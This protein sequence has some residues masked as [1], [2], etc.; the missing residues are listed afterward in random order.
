MLLLIKLILA[1]LLGDFV[2]QSSRWV[3]QKELKRHLAWQLYAHSLLHG[4]LVLLL[5]ADITYWVH[6]L[7]ITVSHLII[8]LLKIRIQNYH[9][10]RLWFVLD[11]MLHLLVILAVW[12]ASESPQ[13]DFQ[14][15]SSPAFFTI[16]TAVVFLTIPSSVI[17]K[18]FISQWTPDLLPH[19]ETTASLQD[20]G[21]FIGMLE[22]LFVFGFILS[23]N[24]EAIGFLLAAKSVFRFGDLRESKDRKLTE[25]VLI[26]T[27]LS[28]GLAIVAGVVT[29]HVAKDAIGKLD[30]LKVGLA[31]PGVE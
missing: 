29:L 16:L 28:F 4:F 27:L 22:R 25:Y 11:Q 23:N 19:G 7:I 1:H 17:I 18:T 26:G 5:M 6:A 15:L 20:A 10:R 2:F 30:L 12:F 24:W 8:D 13:F 21:K 9:T 3:E 14:F 31:I